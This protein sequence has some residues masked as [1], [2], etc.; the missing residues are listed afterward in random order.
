LLFCAVAPLPASAGMH[1]S[2]RLAPAAT[3]GRTL[4][5]QAARVYQAR[6]IDRADAKRRYWLRVMDRPLPPPVAGLARLELHQLRHAADWQWRRARALARA[7][8]RPPHFAEWQCIHSHEAGAWSTNT[9]N[10]YYGGLQMDVNFQVAF[11]GWL[12]RAKGTAERWTPVEQMWAAERAH[13][14]GL[15]FHPWPNT[16]RMC[17]LL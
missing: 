14:S 9:G 11:G 1:V 2:P 4:A 13:D 16:A 17:G 6:R 10:G 7:A 3:S 15:G 12:Y 8:R 5:I